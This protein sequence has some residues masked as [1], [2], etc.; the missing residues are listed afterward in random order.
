VPRLGGKIKR[1]G[2]Q[3]KLITKMV[4]FK[5]ITGNDNVRNDC[6]NYNKNGRVRN[7]CK[8][9]NVKIVTKI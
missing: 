2:R 3:Q 5:K 4:T 7:Y 6:K 9:D 1:K 8:N